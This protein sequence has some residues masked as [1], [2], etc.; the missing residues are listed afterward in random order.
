M[1]ALVFALIFILTANTSKSST[2][3]RIERRKNGVGKQ[4]V[5]A[6]L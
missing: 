6:M 4:K 2:I 5:G 3:N 1:D